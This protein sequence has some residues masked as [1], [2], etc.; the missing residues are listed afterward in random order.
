MKRMNY[1]S[2]VRAYAL[3]LASLFSALALAAA[4]PH[5]TR[6][7]GPLYR[8]FAQAISRR[9]LACMIA[10]ARHQFNREQRQALRRILWLQVNVAWAIDATEF[11]TAQG[12]L[13]VI[14]SRELASRFFLQPEFCSEPDAELVAQHLRRLFQKHT[15]PLLLKRDNGSIFNAEAVDQVLAEFGVIPLNSPSYYAP[16]NGSIENGIGELKNACRQWLGDPAQHPPQLVVRTT[17]ALLLQRNCIPRRSLNDRSACEAF[18]RQ[19]VRFTRHERATIFS[20]LC[21]RWS[22]IMNHMDNVNRYVASAL[23]R[24]VVVNWLRCQHLVDFAP[25]PNVLPH[26]AN[27]CAQN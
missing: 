20:S 24:S 27:L 17:Q 2:T 9:D 18:Y 25:N 8:D 7:T 19:S 10:E 16:Y 5:R 4:P 13:F 6:Q 21:D 12:K 23:W 11:H 3:A 26:S 1:D 22:A 14:A 15:P